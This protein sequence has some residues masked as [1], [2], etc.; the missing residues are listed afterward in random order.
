M[1]LFKVDLK[2]DRDWVRIWGG[3]GIGDYISYQNILYI[4]CAE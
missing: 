3:I 1:K 2:K 4:Y